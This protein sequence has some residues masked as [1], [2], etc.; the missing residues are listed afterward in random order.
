MVKL[1]RANTTSTVVTSGKEYKVFEDD[2]F[3]DDVGTRRF[4]KFYQWATEPNLIKACPKEL[5]VASL[6][7]GISFSADNI[8]SIVKYT[9]KDIIAKSVAFTK[10]TGG[11]HYTD[12]EL[13][14]LEATYL[15]YGLIGLKA[16]IHTKVDK[17]ITRKKDDEIVQLE[18]AEH[19]LSILIEITKLEK[20]YL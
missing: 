19:C 8:V 1:L 5:T 12:Q 10:Q 16:A 9:R 20:E 6:S 15:R 4:T 14:P 2:T 17:Y 18:K 13:Q 11:H 3:R 7:T